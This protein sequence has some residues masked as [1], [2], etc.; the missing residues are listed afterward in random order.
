MN[1][2]LA[3][4]LLCALLSACQSGAPVWTETSQ[5]IDVTCSQQSEGS[6]RFVATRAELSAAQLDM[7]SQ[8]RTTDPSG[9][10]EDVMF[11][12]LAIAQ[13]DGHTT[14]IDSIELNSAC[15]GQETVV[16]FDSFDPFRRSIGCQY[17]KNLTFT[18]PMGV[19]ADARCFNGL[20]TGGGGTITVTLAVDD[21]SPHHIELDDCTQPGRLGKISFTVIDSDGMTILGQSSAP[22]DGGP[23]GTCAALDMTFPRSGGYALQVDVASGLLPAGDFYL[24]FY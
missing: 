6:M 14:M 23:D 5:S 3:L 15:G 11:C 4:G 9:C 2:R 16:S 19:T 18:Q 24:R 13:A 1:L 7:L 21:A 12:S 10:V 8:L 20:F 17:A 22:T